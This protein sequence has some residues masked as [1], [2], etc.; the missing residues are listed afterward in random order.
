MN[1]SGS[2]P[3]SPI[4]LTGDYDIER[5]GELAQLF[6]AAEPFI[7]LFI[8]LQDVGYADSTLLSE[9]ALLRKHN[10]TSRIVLIGPPP[11]L[12]TILKLMAFDAVFEIDEHV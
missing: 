1:K 12:L 4:A 7:E 9:L 2:S 5:R 11:Q 10:P 8:D 6:R 3:T